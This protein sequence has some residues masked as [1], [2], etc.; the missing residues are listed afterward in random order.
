MKN[1]GLSSWFKDQSW[2]S[3]GLLITFILSLTA[4]FCKFLIADKI[5]TNFYIEQNKMINKITEI[6]KDQKILTQQETRQIERM[7][8]SHKEHYPTYQYFALHPK[9]NHINDKDIA[10]IN[11]KYSQYS[12]PEQAKKSIGIMADTFFVSEAFEVGD[13]YI[14]H[15]YHPTGGHYYEITVLLASISGVILI[16]WLFLKV[17]YLLWIR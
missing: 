12:Y 11:L 6:I 14:V 2:I 10:P 13:W 1:I 4:T 9:E 16:I 8:Q 7:V 15:Q 3:K 17:K 5:H